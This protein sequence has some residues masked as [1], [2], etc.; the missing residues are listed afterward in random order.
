[1]ETI[2]KHTREVGTSAG[3]LLPR[4]WLNKQVVVTLFEPSKEKILQE[5]MDCLSKHNL[6]EEAKGVY[7][8]GSYSRKDFDFNSDIDILVI[9]QNT[10]KL[11]NYNNY[12]ILLISESSF[13]KN[14]PNNLNYL[15]ILREIKVIFNKDLIEEYK[16]KKYKFNIKKIASEIENVLKINQDSVKMC[17]ENNM[18][19]PD[20]VAYSVVLR[21]REL[22]LIK[23]LISNKSYNK[24]DFLELIGEKAYFAYLRIK[25]NE[26]ELNNL[27]PDELINAMDLSKKWLKELKERKKELKV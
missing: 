11:I 10:K 22:Y 13:S 26:K 23:C 14:L 8:Y 6:N 24:K 27:S 20:G 19:L 18:N 15:S 21:L 5:V 7:L 1:M 25:R 16:S 2:V 4:S 12:E 9:T 17:R 3:V